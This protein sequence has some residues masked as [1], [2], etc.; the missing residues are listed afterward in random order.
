MPVDENLVAAL[1]ALQFAMEDRYSINK[2]DLD[3][4]AHSARR[5]AI[6]KNWLGTNNLARTVS[7]VRAMYDP[8][9]YAGV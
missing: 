3:S 6:K 7:S 4:D 2:L 9:A 1:E 5:H 8:P